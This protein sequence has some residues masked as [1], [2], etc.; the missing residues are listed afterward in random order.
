MCPTCGW[1]IPAEYRIC[2]NCGAGAAPAPQPYY[3]EPLGNIKYVA[4]LVAFLEPFIGLI[5][6]VIWAADSDPEKKRVGT[7][8]ALISVVLLVLRFLLVLILWTMVMG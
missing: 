5:W 3:K 4:Y 2:P 1:S 6:G 8:T 7:I